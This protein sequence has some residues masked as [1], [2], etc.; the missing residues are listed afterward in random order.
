MKQDLNVGLSA[1]LGIRYLEITPERVLAELDIRPEL[2][3]TTN[4]LHGGTLMALAD[5]VGAVGTI[6]HL[7]AHPEAGKGTATIDGILK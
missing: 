5:T 3:T 2:L 7:E 4:T 6:A 1:H